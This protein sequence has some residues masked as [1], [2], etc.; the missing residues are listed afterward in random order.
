MSIQSL[1]LIV[2]DRFGAVV[3]PLRSPLISS[4]LCPFFTLASW[5][6]ALAFFSPYL[7]AYKLVEFGDGKQ[8]CNLQWD[9]AFGSSL[10][11]SYGYLGVQVVFL[12]IPIALLIIIYSV[13]VI[14]LKTE[15]IRGEQ[16]NNAEQQRRERSGKVVKMAIAIVVGFVVCWIPWDI[17]NLLS[18]SA[19]DLPEC[20]IWF[21]DTIP[22]SCLLELCHQPLHLFSF[23]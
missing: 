13:I 1:V 7:F 12:Y 17:M 14:K 21:H 11:F 15:K 19:W 16:S 22:Y 5:I 6:V 23:Q 9:E 18:F 3:S 20:G 10:S 4:K 8:Y 2:V